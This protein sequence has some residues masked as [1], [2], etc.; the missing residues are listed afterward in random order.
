MPI[1]LLQELVQIDSRNPPGNETGVAKY[2]YDWLTDKGIQAELIEWGEN[3][4]NVIAEI[5]N[6]SNGLM[7]SGHIDIVPFGNLE[8]WKYDPLGATIV[9]DK[10]HGR[11]TSD[12]KGGVA[13][14]ME[15]AAK[16]SKENFKR[17][18]LLTFTGDEESGLEGAKFL[19]AKRPEIF[20]G[21]KYGV[22]GE[23]TQLNIRAIH[24][25]IV[26]FKAVF[27]GK[28]AHGSKPW[29]GDN[30]I[31]KANKFI[32]NLQMLEKVLAKK[33]DPML[34]SGTINVGVISGGTKIN[35]VPES[36]EVEV[37]RRITRKETMQ[38]ALKQ[39]Q[40]AAKKADPKVK[41]A[42]IEMRPPLD[43]PLDSPLIEMIQNIT[44]AKVLGE[45]GY[46]E[47]GYFRQKLGIDCVVCGPGDSKLAH[48]ANE[49]ISVKMVDRAAQVYE[50]LIRQQCI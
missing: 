44:K 28:A 46:T 6:G 45:S 37:D 39:L 11:G 41:F 5:G 7:L 32:A 18:L 31:L 19:V 21:I 23:P 29:L 25:G 20:N 49:W 34:G 40:D 13:A 17:K 22:V 4:Y 14:I 16:L 15:A 35:I 27:S 30:A 48:V 12:M 2:I 1:E 10:L 36:C 38:E 42:N 33:K 9:G 26:Q 50:K 47:A 8:N 3:R 43:N 24:K